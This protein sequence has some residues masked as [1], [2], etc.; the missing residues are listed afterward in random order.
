MHDGFFGFIFESDALMYGSALGGDERIHVYRSYTNKHYFLAYAAENWPTRFRLAK[1]A[2]ELS[3]AWHNLCNTKPNR[4]KSWIRLKSLVVKHIENPDLAYGDDPFEVACYLGHDTIVKQLIRPDTDLE[5]YLA[6]AARG[7]YHA[8]VDTLITHGASTTRSGGFGR[9]PLHNG[10]NCGSEKVLNSLLQAGAFVDAKDSDLRTSL[11]IAASKG[12]EAAVKILLCNGAFLDT[13][14]DQGQTPLLS[15]I[16]GSS[17]NILNM[18][19][20]RGASMDIR[21]DFG[22]MPIFRALEGSR[23][24]IVKMLLDKGA[25]VSVR[26]GEGLTPLSYAALMENGRLVK[27]LLQNAHHPNSSNLK[28]AH[29]EPDDEKMRELMVNI[30]PLEA[31]TLDIKLLGGMTVLQWAATHRLDMSVQKPPDKGASADLKDE[32][33]FRTLILA[34]K[35]GHA[36]I[37]RV[38]AAH[39]ADLDVRDCTHE[40]SL[41]KA[42]QKGYSEIVQILFEDG[43][44]VDVADNGDQTALH[45]AA[46]MG[47]NYLIHLLLKAGADPNA[48]S[49]SGQSPWT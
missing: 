30:L 31:Y 12:H 9:T 29:L 2:H 44:P 25:S 34:A 18:M 26:D 19:L 15:A 37:A 11:H 14:D 43:D 33:G 3:Q 22:Q 7:G 17:V 20:V 6:I 36:E 21:D 1:G 16:E 49:I 41:V 40:T 8:V 32:D 24:D 42:V 48:L 28:S 10:A 13:T 47:N 35:Q 4:F 5:K 38:L 46:I 23:V 39:G 27:L 45:H